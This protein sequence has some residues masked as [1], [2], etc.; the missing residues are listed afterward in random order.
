MKY[1]NYNKYINITARYITN[2]CIQ[3]QYDAINGEG[4]EVQAR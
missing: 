2:L 4:Y 1:Y 3:K